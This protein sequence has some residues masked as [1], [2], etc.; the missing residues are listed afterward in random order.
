MV[1]VHIVGLSDYIDFDINLDYWFGSFG[2][3]DYLFY[4]VY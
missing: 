3:L 2:K 1:A 4:F